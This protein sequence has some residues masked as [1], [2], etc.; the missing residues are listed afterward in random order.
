[1]SVEHPRGGGV[2][3]SILKNAAV[4][5]PI[6][7]VTSGK[8]ASHDTTVRVAARDALYFIVGKNAGTAPD[9]AAWDPVVTYLP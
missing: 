4:V 2:N 8:P 7:A 1:M 6:R 9:R 3:A 5:W